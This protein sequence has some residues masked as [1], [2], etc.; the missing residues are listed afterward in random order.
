MQVFL[1]PIVLVSNASYTSHIVLSAMLH[2]SRVHWSINSIASLKGEALVT[3][4]KV[5]EYTD[6]EIVLWAILKI[7]GQALDLAF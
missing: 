6:L 1:S 4:R 7:G 5:S 3:E 2:L